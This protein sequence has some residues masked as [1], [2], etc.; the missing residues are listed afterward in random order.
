MPSD[1]A[2]P[3]HPLVEKGFEVWKAR[4]EQVPTISDVKVTTTDDITE[5]S[6][7]FS[8]RSMVT[9]GWAKTQQTFIADGAGRLLHASSIKSVPA[10]TVLSSTSPSGKL[11]VELRKAAEDP[12]RYLRVTSQAAGVDAELDVSDSHLDFLTSGAPLD[13]ISK[14]CLFAS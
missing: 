12:K 9:K 14:Y 2:E 8:S 5:V 10:E 3:M 6:A 13:C 4:S 11:T 1:I 7:T